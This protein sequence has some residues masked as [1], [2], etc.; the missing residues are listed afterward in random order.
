MLSLSC[1]VQMTGTLQ[2]VQ[3]PGTGLA[4]LVSMHIFF[5]HFHAMSALNTQTNAALHSLPI[6]R[7]YWTM[8]LDRLGS[9]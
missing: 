6:L 4:L 7:L 3:P 5:L 9:N 8:E 1:L 2:E